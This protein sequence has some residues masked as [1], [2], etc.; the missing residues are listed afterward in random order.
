MHRI[1]EVN[2]VT[3]HHDR[4]R[5]WRYGGCLLLLSLASSVFLVAAD[6]NDIVYRAD[7]PRTLFRPASEIQLTLPTPSQC[8][9][10]FGLACYTPQ[11]MRKAHNI[12]PQWTGKGQSIIIVGETVWNNSDP[13][14]CPFGCRRGRS[15]ATGGAPSFTFAAPDFQLPLTGAA[16]RLTSD[17]SYNANFYTAVLVYIGFFDDPA[18]NGLYFFGGTSA[19]A[20]QWAAIMADINEARG[21][22]QGY[23]NPSLYAIAADPARY[24]QAFHDVT[25]GHNAFRGPRVSCRRRV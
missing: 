2:A 6:S 24:A 5:R 3:S 7:P 19:E 10:A 18:R 1:V 8:A 14:L 22:S 11:L 20:P 4:N 21:F 25:I 13:S 9:A 17:V 16:A 12:P 15:G 23:L